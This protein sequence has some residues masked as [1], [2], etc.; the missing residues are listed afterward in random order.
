MQ[1]PVSVGHILTAHE[2]RTFKQMGQE[3]KQNHTPAG[4]ASL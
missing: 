4:Q 3:H 2:T 1:H